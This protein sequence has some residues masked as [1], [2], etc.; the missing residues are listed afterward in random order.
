MAEQRRTL[1]ISAA[2]D[3]GRRRVPKASEHVARELATRI[4]DA[5]LPPGAMLPTERELVAALA[6]GRTTVR[7]AL[8]LL[9]TRGVITIRTGPGGGPVVR[10]PRPGDLSEALSLILEFE[11]A[12]IGEVLEAK[13]A[14]EPAV[15]RLAATRVTDEVL[16][17]L[18]QTV[19]AMR[20]GLDDDDVLYAE[21]GRFHAVLADASGNAVLRVFQATLRSISNGAELGA[22]YPLPF[23]DQV[24][25]AHA[26]I[27]EALRA[28]DPAAVEDALKAHLDEI[29]RYWHRE[30]VAIV[31]RPVTWA[32]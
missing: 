16:A 8:R 17:T 11:G 27:L 25:D 30:H 4:V 13:E 12:S 32:G 23:R 15:A 19:A 5:G 28:G 3:D 2:R 9:E 1:A 20:S 24:A 7:E 18:E 14:L 6:V 26:R 22:R 31:E 10:R 21:S 29:G